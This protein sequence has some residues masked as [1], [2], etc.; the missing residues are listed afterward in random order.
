MHTGKI[1][2]KALNLRRSGWSLGEIARALEIP[3]ST[4]SGWTKE[5]KLTGKQKGRIKEK[6][7]ES[8]IIGRR[9]ALKANLAKLNR[10]KKGIRERVKHYKDLATEKTE[11]G[12][13]ICGILYLC[14]GAKYPSSRFLY[15]GNSDPRVISAFI[16]LLR[17]CYAIKEEK[18]RFDIR[19]RWDQDLKKLRIF[20]SKVTRIPVKQCLNSQPDPR[21]K[22][23][24]TLRKSYKGVC[25]V[26]YYDSSLQFVLQSIGENIINKWCVLEKVRICLQRSP[27][28]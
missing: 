10:W 17:K 9:L 8:G 12:K 26:I 5:I 20:W 7:I 1:K 28:K 27:L 3:R 11:F 6:I 21:T 13:I 22:G 14:E 23:S 4:L 2:Q 18:L 19:Y 25:R 24:P 16:N 15:F